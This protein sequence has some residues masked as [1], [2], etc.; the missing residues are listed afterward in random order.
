MQCYTACAAPFV[1]QFFRRAPPKLK[2]IYY[3]DTKEK[4]QMIISHMAC[5]CRTGVKFEQCNI[6][7]FCLIR[8]TLFNKIKQN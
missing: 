5:F 8:L 4:D 7:I 3:K 6:N 1:E 2:N